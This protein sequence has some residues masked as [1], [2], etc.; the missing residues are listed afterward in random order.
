MPKGHTQE[1]WEVFHLTNA[2]NRRLKQLI[3]EQRLE[4]GLCCVWCGDYSCV[5][6]AHIDHTGVDGSS[7]GRWKRYYDVK[8]NKD[9]FMLMCQDCHRDF[10]RYPILD[11][12]D[13]TFRKGTRHFENKKK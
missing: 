13:M 8:K 6:F 5:E 11:L 7:R 10:D 12:D 2:W 4:F 9:K 3:F 1:I